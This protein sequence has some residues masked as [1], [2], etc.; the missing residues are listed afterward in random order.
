M[1]ARP[2]GKRWR[3]RLLGAVLLAA[4]L[5]VGERIV[6][7]L[8]PLPAEALRP[9]ASSLV[10]TDAEGSEL[11]WADRDGERRRWVPLA[12]ISPHLVAAVIAGEDAR[13][14]RHGGVDPLAT[15][16]ALWNNLAHGR[17]TSGASTITM[18][19]V[20]LVEPAPRTWWAKMR[21]AVRARQLERAL[22]KDAIL[23]QYLNRAP[24]GGRLRGVEAASRWWFGVPAADLTPA[25]AAMLAAMLPSPT[26]RSPIAEAALLRDRRDRLLARLGLPPAE[27]A[28][29]LDTPL[30]VAPQ[31]FPW[32][33]P[34]A[35]DAALAER[36]HAGDD[37]RLDL[38]LARQRRVADALA[39]A[40]RPGDALAVVACDADG[41]IEV[42]LGSADWRG[43]VFDAARAAR[44]AG[45]TLKPFLYRRAFADGALAPGAPLADAP[46]EV[47]G[48][49]PDNEDER[50]RGALPAGEALARSRNPPAVRALQAIGL[51][52]FADELAAAGLAQ[53]VTGLDAALGTGAVT[54]IALA[55][56]YAGLGA[57]AADDAAAAAVLAALRTR[58]FASDLIPDRTVAWKTGTSAHRRDAWC[59][60]VPPAGGAVVVWL[61]WNDGRGDPGLRGRDAAR[62]CCALAV[63]ALADPALAQRTA[64]WRGVRTGLAPH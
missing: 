23:E 10:I 37:L 16:R 28:R 52:A 46:I 59:V 7:R 27:L 53:P 60:A 64:A 55:R 51:D 44:A 20:R 57:R 39:A 38:R 41:R 12:R 18:Q 21:E 8:W 61:G 19:V 26:R 9:Y 2:P 14:R 3:R 25:Q 22:A 11:R 15:M 33:A 13:F 31:P 17:R 40:D 30:P 58:P 63:A 5:L 24:W 50:W 62:R 54:P 35:C 6:G 45:S 29:A 42:H 56:A 47:A 34:H 48:W 43:T 4:A 1:S 36:A 32:L 49:R